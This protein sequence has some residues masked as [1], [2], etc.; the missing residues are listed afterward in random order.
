MNSNLIV[1]PTDFSDC[2]N[3]AMPYVIALGKALKCKI[4][5]VHAIEIGSLSSAEE[6]PDMRINLIKL[7]E[8]QATKKLTKRKEEIET[9]GLECDYDVIQGRSLFL[10]EYMENLA[11][12]LIVMGTIGKHGLENKIFGSFATQTIRNPKSIVLAIPE[13]AKFNNLSE[14]VFA[15]DFHL[16]DKSCLE[17]IKKIR[18]YYDANLRVI[19]VN[20]NFT[21][22]K[23]EKENFLQLEAEIIKVIGSRDLSFELLY[24][25]DVDDKLLELLDSSKPDMLALITRKRNFIERI[26]DK[27]LAKKMVN[28]TN[29][30]VLVFS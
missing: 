6:S 19:H 12:L 5:M 15:T 17:F 24:G 29:V 18:K 25:D 10:K 22:L 21:D 8:E 13:K 16:K 30:P 1:Y 23:Q 2:A 9:L 14:I 28:H 3:N 11:P 7:L 27:S 4:K 26:F 20:D